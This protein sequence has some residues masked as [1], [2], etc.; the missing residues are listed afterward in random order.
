[1]RLRSAMCTATALA[2]LVFVPAAHAGTASIDANIVDPSQPVAT[3][4]NYVA[5]AGEQNDLTVT[6]H[7]GHWL[8]H[9]ATAPM[10]TTNCQVIDEHTVDCNAGDG[11]ISGNS[12]AAGLYGV[13]LDMG[14]GDDTVSAG[15]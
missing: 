15:T 13:T 5:A 14:D 10:K 11:P 3:F 12:E 6:Y 4:L 1:M 9:D 8:F 2:V 7:D